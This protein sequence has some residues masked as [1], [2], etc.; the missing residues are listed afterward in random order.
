MAIWI[1]RFSINS[2]IST[3]VDT[4]TTSATLM[5]LVSIALAYYMIERRFALWQ[6][7][8]SLRESE[9]Q[10]RQRAYELQQAKE[11]A[12]AANRAKSAFLTNMSH[13]LRTPLNA[14]LGF[15]Q[16]MA[17]DPHVTPT[18][19]EYLETIA[20]S[21]EHLLGLIN[22]VL[23]MS[24]IE[25]GRTT[26]QENAF[27]LHWQLRGLQEIFQLRAADKGLVLLL[28]IAPDVPRYVYAD[29]GKLRQVLMNILS[30]AVKFT[31]EGGVTLRVRSKEYQVG[32]REYGVGS[33]E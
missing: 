32:S 29:E 8:S 23:T 28:D 4:A 9:A 20:R 14:I 27:D 2:T 18:Q 5:S 13:E 21:G 15:S 31:K 25:A 12:E 7:E 11:A 24:K 1:T 6:A 16:L 22:D 10:S 19:R 33:R 17:R 26:L 30:N 3:P